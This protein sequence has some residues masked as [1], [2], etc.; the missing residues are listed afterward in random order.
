MKG[1]VST[2]LVAVLCLVLVPVAHAQAGS[3]RKTV[4]KRD[5]CEITTGDR[6]ADGNNLVI[7]YCDWKLPI[8]KLK[9]AFGDAAAHDDYLTSV[10][11]STILADGRVL[12]VH[13]ASG[14]ADRQ[15][16]LA[17]THEDLDGGG[18]KVS[19][20]RADKQEPLGKGRVDAPLDDGHWQVL[21]GK[22]GVHKVEYSLRYDPGGKVPI[23]IVRA[24]QKGGTAD[25][26]KEMLAAASKL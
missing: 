26:L 10:V 7:A 1:F 18:Y 20:T 11:E 25:I 5:N 17:F 8:E 14:I 24:F 3:E 12:Q 21:P 19:W 6:D 4:L 23:W 2:L 22:E 13:Q 9:K 16:T 15:I